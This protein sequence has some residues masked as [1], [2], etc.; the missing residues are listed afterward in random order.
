MIIKDKK[1]KIAAL[2]CALLI[3]DITAHFTDK[4]TGIVK[5][6]ALTQRYDED[7]ESIWLNM[8]FNSSGDYVGD[9]DVA[10]RLMRKGIRPEVVGDHQVCSIGFCADEQK[11]YGWSHRA[12]CGFTVGSEC[13]RGDCHFT[14]SDIDEMISVYIS[15]GISREDIKVVNN[16]YGE[17]IG[18]NILPITS[19]TRLIPLG[20]GEWVAKTLEDAQEMAI[21]FA[22]AV[23]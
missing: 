23:S 12:L 21:A 22:G 18:I 13:R 1:E 16:A 3:L 6:R 8:A 15:K 10:T 19:E 17:P 2:K 11:W 14:P 5:V 4:K 20:R 9:Y 7:T